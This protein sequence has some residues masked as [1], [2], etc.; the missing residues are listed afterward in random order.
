MTRSVLYILLILFPLCGFCQENWTTKKDGEQYGFWD[1][2]SQKFMLNQRFDRVSANF[3]DGYAV[4]AQKNETGKGRSFW[5]GIV[6]VNGNMKLPYGDQHVTH[7]GLGI[8]SIFTNGGALIKNL[9]NGKTISD[10][11]RTNCQV[12]KDLQEVKVSS[13][14]RHGIYDL[15]G[16]LKIEAMGSSLQRMEHARF[17]N[18]GKIQWLPFYLIYYEKENKVTGRYDKF[19]KIVDL[20]GELINISGKKMD[21]IRLNHHATIYFN[22]TAIFTESGAAI[23]NGEMKEIIPFSAGYEDLRTISDSTLVQAI[24]NGKTG[25]INLKGEIVLPFQFEDCSIE[26]FRDGIYGIRSYSSSWG[27]AYVNSK[28]DYLLPPGY[29]ADGDQELIDFKSPIVVKNPDYYMGV[30]E[31]GKGVIIPL[32][33]GYVSPI[34]EGRVVVS[35]KDSAAIVNLKGR[36]YFKLKCNHLTDL[37]EGVSIVGHKGKISN[38]FRYRYV[39]STGAP[40]HKGVYND[41]RPFVNGLA[42]VTKGDDVFMINKKGEQVYFEDSVF[43]ISY[44]DNGYAFVS[45]NDAELGLVDLEGNIIKSPSIVKIKKKWVDLPKV[46]N[47]GYQR[48]PYGRSKQVCVPKI[49]NG[50]FYEK[51]FHTWVE[52]DLPK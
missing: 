35:D 40:I 22:R 21:R 15:E 43:L 2:E 4:V 38:Q 46:P 25:L 23:V 51:K 11:E 6:D 37:Q 20:K 9:D 47:D 16:N 8:V 31:P 19:Q 49:E 36:T 10:D 45:N 32:I 30:Y 3:K 41:A 39:D 52:A 28:G 18:K 17:Q 48:N 1:E 42:E 26:E 13:D 24:K 33:Y 29:I 5:Y 7:Q 12:Y 27:S 44:Y 34:Y 50:H 14:S